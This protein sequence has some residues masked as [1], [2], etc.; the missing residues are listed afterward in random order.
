M[1]G[2]WFPVGL[3]LP[4]DDITVL[5]ADEK[6]EVWTAYLSAGQWFYVCGERLG[7]FLTHWMHLPDAPEG[8]GAA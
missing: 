3:T 2:P 6:G 4:D 8:K 1:S 7:S 5:V